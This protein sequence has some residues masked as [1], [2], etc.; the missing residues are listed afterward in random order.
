L[1]FMPSMT[2]TS[3]EIDRALAIL[4]ETLTELYGG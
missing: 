2:V 4:N 1:R 3:A